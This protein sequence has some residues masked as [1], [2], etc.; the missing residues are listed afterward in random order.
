MKGEDKLK[1]ASFIYDEDGFL[2]KETINQ[3][4]NK[5]QV[6]GCTIY[7]DNLKAKKR[8]IS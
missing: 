8:E 1:I 7:L 4:A 6:S 2:I 5:L 3:V